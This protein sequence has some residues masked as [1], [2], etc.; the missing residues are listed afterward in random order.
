MKLSLF[1]TII[2]ALT[3]AHKLSPR[4]NQDVMTQ[5]QVG[6]S[7]DAQRWT[8]ERK[9]KRK[10]MGIELKNWLEEEIGSQEG[11][12][13]FDA[14]WDQMNSIY[15]E[16]MGESLPPK[17]K[18]WAQSQFEQADADKNGIIY[19]D[20]IRSLITILKLNNL[21]K[22]RKEGD[23]VERSEKEPEEYI[24]NE[25]SDKGLD[26]TEDRISDE[27]DKCYAIDEKVRS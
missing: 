7:V 26:D 16:N 13:T 11:G 10:Q 5:M 27:S 18:C 6:A 2:I 24:N 12:L 23:D 21:D 15:S 14:L 9:L 20:E 1:L 4:D 8:N 22:K 3:S 17:K 19:G 25:E